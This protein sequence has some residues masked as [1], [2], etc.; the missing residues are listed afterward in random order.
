MKKQLLLSLL[1]SAGLSASA[2]VAIPDELMPYAVSF[3]E[4]VGNAVLQ[5]PDDGDPYYEFWQVA[6]SAEEVT[7]GSTYGYTLEGTTYP[8][9]LTTIHTAAFGNRP[10]LKRVTLP[11]SVTSMGDNTFS[12]NG[13]IPQGSSNLEYVKLSDNIAVIPAQAFYQCAKLT[14]VVMPQTLTTIDRYAFTDCSSLQSI[15]LPATLTSIGYSAFNS[16]GLTSV[17]IPAAVTNIDQMAFAGC[18]N[19]ESVVFEGNIPYINADVF[20]L[21]NNL[22]TVTFMGTTPP[23]IVVSGAF[24]TDHAITYNV[25]AGTKAAYAAALGVPASQINDG[26]IVVP[27]GLNYGT[28]YHSNGNASTAYYAKWI[29]TPAAENI[30]AVTYKVKSGN[31]QAVFVSGQMDLYGSATTNAGTYEFSIN[32]TDYYIS[33]ISFT[34][35]A[36][37]ANITIKPSNSSTATSIAT[38]GTDVS[39]DFPETVVEPSFYINTSHAIFTNFTVT[40]TP[41]SQRTVEP[42]SWYVIKSLTVAQNKLAGLNPYGVYRHSN[43]DY[44]M[45][46]RE[47]N[48]AADYSEVSPDC[49]IHVEDVNA[50]ANQIVIRSNNGM[51]MNDDCTADR[52]PNFTNIKLIETTDGVKVRLGSTWSTFSQTI[53][54]ADGTTLTNVGLGQSGGAGNNFEMTKVNPSERFDIWTVNILKSV[55]HTDSIFSATPHNDMV[56]YDVRLAINSTENHG[57]NAVYNGGKFFLTKGYTPV[58]DD[59]APEANLGN[60]N[61]EII[62]DA[63]TKTISVDYNKMH[64]QAMDWNARLETVKT[65]NESILNEAIAHLTATGTHTADEVRAMWDAISVGNTEGLDEDEAFALFEAA[66]DEVEHFVTVTASRAYASTL[67]GKKVKLRATRDANPATSTNFRYMKALA[68]NFGNSTPTLD[69]QSVWTLHVDD[70]YGV[71]V[72][73]LALDK[74]V[75]MG[76]ANNDLALLVDAEDDNVTTFNLEFVLSNYPGY[77]AIIVNGS[78][79]GM[80]LTANTR[81]Y[82]I[83]SWEKTAGADQWFIEL[84]DDTDEEAFIAAAQANVTAQTNAIPSAEHIT[85]TR[86]DATKTEYFGEG[87]SKFSYVENGEATLA[88]AQAGVTTL[89]AGDNFSYTD[90]YAYTALSA[91][92]IYTFNPVEPGHFIRIKSWGYN[93]STHSG[94][95]LGMTGTNGVPYFSNNNDSNILYFHGNGQTDATSGAAKGYLMDYHS[96]YGVAMS[97]GMLTAKS[98]ASTDGTPNGAQEIWLAPAFASMNNGYYTQDRYLLRY[99]NGSTDRYSYNAGTAGGPNGGGSVSAT[100]NHC[101]SFTVEYVTELPVSIVNGIGSLVCPMAVTVPSDCKVWVAELN[102]STLSWRET[103]SIAA[104]EHAVIYAPNPVNGK[105]YVTIDAEQAPYEYAESD[106]LKGHHLAMQHSA[107]NVNFVLDLDAV[108]TDETDGET[109]AEPTGVTLHKINTEAA[110]VTLRPHTFALNVTSPNAVAE[111]LELPFNEAVNLADVNT[112]ISEISVDGADAAVVYDLQG[113]RLSKPVKGAVNVINGKKIYVY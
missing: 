40:L 62:I 72:Q 22:Q 44:S 77:V 90:C 74:Y 102:G 85:G 21:C 4:N 64:G 45:S 107:E 110:N 8:I 103:N 3:G 29:S 2:V 60:D 80:H 17:T 9:Q 52:D 63:A 19:L 70:N 109:P 6:A 81:N 25:P 27:V 83:L 46:W 87:P 61:P 50:L 36:Q 32:S 88:A 66:E 84:V 7:L 82:E 30:P 39:F 47:Y 43:G 73:N 75:S 11:N 48:G 13:A 53:T 20:K 104:G 86:S 57:W 58:F 55:N 15:E 38:T 65:E 1:L 89:E 68:T 91:A 41:K 94:M 67:N 34:A 79:N 71:K 10:N 49:Y 28:A 99:K 105:I 23:S 26:S 56:K 33:N 12:W 59:F 35:T 76:P 93:D 69:V 97:G 16:A 111:T 112:S 14:T 113:R 98:A 95:S 42:D 96:G 108:G 37:A 101:Y 100:S 106:H 31:N 24:P 51:Y 5:I 18:T 78:S 54:N 92:D